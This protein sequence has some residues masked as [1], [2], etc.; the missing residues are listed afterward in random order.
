VLLPLEIPSSHKTVFMTRAELDRLPEY[1]MSIPTGATI[2]KRGRRNANVY[3]RSPR[4]THL[5]FF[6]GSP[7]L[8][9]PVPEWWIGEFVRNPAAE[10]DPDGIPKTVLIRWAKVA[11]VSRP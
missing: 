1:S 9:D 2:G 8:V 10:L 11:L 7:V 5:H 3:E 6:D 4:S